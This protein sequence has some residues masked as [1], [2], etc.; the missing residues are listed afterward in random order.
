MAFCV[1][2]GYSGAQSS[3]SGSS[4]AP[5]PEGL[6]WDITMVKTQPGMRDDYLKG[7]GQTLKGAMEEQKKQSIIMDDKVLLGDASGRDDLNILIMDQ[8][9]NMAAV[10]GVR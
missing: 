4:G 9:Q 6:V 5:Y 2:A 10:D 7:L 1:V 3:S 8:Y